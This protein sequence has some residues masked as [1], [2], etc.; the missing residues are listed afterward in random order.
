MFSLYKSKPLVG[1]TSNIHILSHLYLQS[2][3]FTIDKSCFH[4]RNLHLFC[5]LVS[6][7]WLVFSLRVSEKYLDNKPFIYTPI[8]G[9]SNDS[10]GVH[11][12][13]VYEDTTLSPIQRRHLNAIVQRVCPEHRS[14]HV[15]DGNTFRAAQIY[16]NEMCLFYFQAVSWFV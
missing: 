13:C 1:E 2:N 16:K 11:E 5:W 8:D 14:T 7:Q 6:K 3:W 12:I 10:S 15:V 4:L 9:V